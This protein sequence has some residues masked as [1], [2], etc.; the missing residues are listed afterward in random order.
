MIASQM[1]ATRYRGRI[2]WMLLTCRPDLLPI[3]LKRQG[4]AAVHIPLFY[5]QDDA[6]V[7]AM[8]TTMARKNKI[9]LAT[10]TLPAGLAARQLSG[11][12]IES[13]VLEA[14]RRALAARRDDVSGA[15][16]DA[17]LADFIPSV[18]GL[19][20]ELQELAAV[21]ECTQLQLLPPA[22]RQ[23]VMPPNGRV[24]LQERL[25]AIRQLIEA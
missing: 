12:D 6:E 19:E 4:R 14:R 13:V 24:Q 25:V 8:L 5:P 18:Q 15:D 3:D 7:Q 1:G 23:R 9:T 10:D 2:V 11:A 20:K 16:L 22:W 21:L 17:A